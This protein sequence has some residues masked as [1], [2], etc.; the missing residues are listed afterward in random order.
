MNASDDEGEVGPEEEDD[1]D[2][3]RD[4]EAAM[5]SETE[6]AELD[7]PDAPSGEGRPPN[8]EK[9]KTAKSS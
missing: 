6:R 9:S 2:K 1:G 3:F 5:E 4:A 7:I 8:G